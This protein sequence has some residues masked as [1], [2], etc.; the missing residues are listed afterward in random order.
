[1][2]CP[3]NYSTLPEIE[4]ELAAVS[5]QIEKVEMNA[6]AVEAAIAGVGTYR[7]YSGEDVFLKHNLRVVQQ[8]M[9]KQLRGKE[10][11]FQNQ[12]RQLLSQLATDSG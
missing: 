10:R 6:A 3:T 1:M 2:D 11:G 4:K 5:K 8:I 9:V 12:R 7:G